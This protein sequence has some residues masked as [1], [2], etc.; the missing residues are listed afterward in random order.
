MSAVSIGDEDAS[1]PVIPS[2]MPRKRAETIEAV[3][4]H[5]RV[6]R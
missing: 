1:A 5:A 2:P 6:R 4:G 3:T